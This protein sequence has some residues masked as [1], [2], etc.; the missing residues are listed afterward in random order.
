MSAM[1]GRMQAAFTAGELDPR[2]YDRTSLKYFSTGAATMQNVVV[3]PQGGFTIRDGTRHIG[4]LRADA[5]R[6]FS[7]DASDGSS[8]DLVFMTGQFE[9]WGETGLLQRVAVP[10][11]AAMLPRL[12][13]AQQL[14]TMVM[15]DKDLQSKRIRLFA[16]TDWRVDDAPF[17][18]IPNYDYGDTYTNGV[19]AQWSLEFVGLEDG[20]TVFKITVSNQEAAA[21]TFNSNLTAL[22]ATIETAIVGLAGVF[23]GI[24]VSKVGEKIV[25][26]FDGARNI[27]DGWAVSAAV[28]NKADAAIL[29]AKIRIGIEPGEPLIS[30]ARGWPR[31]GAFYQQRLLIGGFKGLPNAWMASKAGSYFNYDKRFNQADGPFLIPMDVAGGEIILRIVPNLNL[32]IFTSKAEYWLAER[33]LSR[34]Q[35]PNHVQA[36]RNGAR[37]GVPIVENEGAALFVRSNGNVIDEVRYTDVEGNFVSTDVSLLAPHLVEDVRDQ[38]IRDAVNST[39]GNQLAAVLGNGTALIATF[40]RAQEVTAYARFHTDGNV[41]ATS[42][43]GRNE[44]SF[45]MERGG[46][47]RF[48]RM[49]G[50]LLLDEAQTFVFPTPRSTVGGLGRFTGRE[51]WAIADGNIQGPFQVAGNSIHLPVPALNV[52]VGSWRPPVVTT[53]PPP[54]D[55][56]PNIVLKRKARIHTVHL[57]LL[58]TTSV[59]IA[60]NGGKP[61][62]IDLLRYGAARADVPELEQPFSGVIKISGLTGFRDEPSVTITQTRPGRLT[63]RSLTVE[64]Q[65]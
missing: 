19:S 64:A 24:D 38:A 6:L 62:D 56:G 13:S 26:T 45:I 42:T 49:E 23:S 47:R 2:L 36:S 43:N 32:L 22:A 7:F 25:I 53:L 21:I 51:I 60:T 28:I 46:V 27:G 34:D 44:L 35:A 37:E 61:S 9:A 10:V 52:T 30:A 16:P 8:Y 18:G 4:N 65:L 58:D 1:P 11:T 33:A 15:F 39:S 40:L 54:R 31:C 41:I 57:S 63:V 55:I 17:N 12:T 20:V 48:E 3:I 14:D 5:K 59:A 29:A 50:G